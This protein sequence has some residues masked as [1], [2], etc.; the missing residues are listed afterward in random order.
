LEFLDGLR[1]LAALFVVLHHAYMEVPLAG[2]WRQP[3]GLLK[4]LKFGHHA[5]AVFIVLSGYCLMLPVVRDATGW[6]QGGVVGY[7]LRRARRIL[8][9]YYAAFVLCL[10]LVLTLPGMSSLRSDR[11][12][13][14]LPAL[15]PDVLTSHLLLIHN[16][17][18]DWFYR[19]DPPMW[20]VA[21][22][23]QIYFLFPLLLVIWRRAG[24]LAT[25]FVAFTSGLSVATL[26]TAQKWEAIWLLSPWYLGLFALGMAGAHLTTSA[27]MSNDEWAS[28]MPWTLMYALLACATLGLLVAFPDARVPIDI[29]VG[30]ATVCLIVACARQLGAGHDLPRGFGIRVFE[31]RWAVGLGAFSYSLYLI[32]YPVLSTVHRLLHSAGWRSEIRLAFMLMVSAPLCVIVAYVFHLAFEKPFLDSLSRRRQT[33]PAVPAISPSP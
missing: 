3:F 14:A 22:E 19:I 27:R 23:W 7:G 1:G 6:L 5:V 31:S 26:A 4:F 18:A 25:V 9:A 30:M 10:L 17:R 16:L 32:H 15:A 13:L 33:L 12:D 24:M 21:T 8:P 20:S 2:S 11:W 29:L 28:R